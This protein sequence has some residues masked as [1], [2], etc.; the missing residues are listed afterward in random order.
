MGAASA[1]FA[2]NEI[3]PELKTSIHLAYFLFGKLDRKVISAMEVSLNLRAAHRE[4]IRRFIGQ[5]SN[6]NDGL[7]SIVKPH[8]NASHNTRYRIFGDVCK[9]AAGNPR[10]DKGFILRLV[11]IGQA[12]GISEDEVFRAIKQ[13]GLAE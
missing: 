4:N 13:S 6:T 5:I 3:D 10:F 1:A 7:Q 2:Q 9:I 8:R 12:L 11:E